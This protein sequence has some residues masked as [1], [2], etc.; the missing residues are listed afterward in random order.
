MEELLEVDG[1]DMDGGV[2]MTKS[3]THIDFQKC[4]FGGEVC[5]VI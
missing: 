4:D 3:Q 2:E 5:Q 1:F